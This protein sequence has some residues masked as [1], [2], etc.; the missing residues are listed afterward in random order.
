MA[1]KSLGVKARARL[2]SWYIL[3]GGVAC[4]AWAR[5]EHA[6]ETIALWNQKMGD[7]GHITEPEVAHGELVSKAVQKA[8]GS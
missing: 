6:M 4:R 7:K 1:W 3:A 5:N 8:L 2:V